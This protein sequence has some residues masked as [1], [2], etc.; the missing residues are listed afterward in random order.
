MN[1]H[2]NDD[3]M[4]RATSKLIGLILKMPLEDRLRLLTLVERKELDEKKYIRRK[5]DRKDL[6][7]N[8]AYTIKDRL[9]KG[10]SVNLSDNGVF[11]EFPKNN[12]PEFSL[13]DN[14]TLSFYHPF[15]EEQM[16]ITG[17]IARIE[18]KGIGVMFDQPILE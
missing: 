4:E 15:R 6:L 3:K 12:S 17:R 11:I 5:S 14:V 2:S 1:V 16:K 10:S 7:I 18:K 9:Y 8:I 13:G